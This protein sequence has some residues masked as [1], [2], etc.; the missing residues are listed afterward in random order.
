MLIISCIMVRRVRL[1]EG[2][3]SRDTVQTGFSARGRLSQG[4]ALMGCMACGVLTCVFR[5]EEA[6]SLECAS[7]HDE[8]RCS[9]SFKTTLMGCC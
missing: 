3:E 6:L 1:G 5:D 9:G 7:E 2:L 4:A 8:I